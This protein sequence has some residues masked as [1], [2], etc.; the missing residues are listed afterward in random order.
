LLGRKQRQLS[1]LLLGRIEYIDHLGPSGLLAVID[2]TQVK[3]VSLH[4]PA[5]GDFDL[6]SNRPVAVILAVLETV[7]T[8]QKRSGHRSGRHNTST[9]TGGGRA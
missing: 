5:A 7:M 9:A 6:F 8:V 3:D 2:F 4:P 1:G